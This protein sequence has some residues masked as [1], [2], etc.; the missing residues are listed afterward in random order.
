MT[1]SLNGKVHDHRLDGFL[2][3]Q[4]KI[5]EFWKDFTPGILEK[6]VLVVGMGGNGSH[7][8]LALTRMGFERITVIDRDRVEPSNLSRQV[9]YSV[10]DIGKLKTESAVKSL[11]NHSFRTKIASIDMDIVSNRKKFVNAIGNHD[12]IFSLLD[13]NGGQF[14][15]S[16][17]CLHKMKPMITGGTDPVSGFVTLYRF[18]AP[19]GKPC[20]E[21]MSRHAWDAPRDWILYYGYPHTPG[22]RIDMEK[23]RMF[24]VKTACPARCASTYIT[25]SA[26]SDLMVSAMLNWFMGRKVPAFVMMNVLTMDICKFSPGKFADCPVC[27]NRKF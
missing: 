11:K 13:S 7:V 6:R 27:G 12:F 10:G 16:S 15:T 24:D 9:I 22:I 8:S 18:Q 17:I 20:E 21:C 1:R 26:G 4:M 3:R 14:L 19:G 5:S 2:D 23:V 25:A